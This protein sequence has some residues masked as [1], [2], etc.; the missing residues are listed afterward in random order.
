MYKNFDKQNSILPYL[1]NILFIEK[2][3]KSLE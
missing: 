3:H 2:L 1:S